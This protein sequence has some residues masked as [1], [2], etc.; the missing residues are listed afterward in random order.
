MKKKF[1]L[2]STYNK[3]GLIPL[4][5]TLMKHNY[6]LIATSG[7]ADFLKKNGLDVV[8]VE[9]ITGFPSMLGGRVKTLHP[10]VFGGILAKGKEEEVKKYDI[11]LID[12]VVVNLYPFDKEPSIEN[13]DIGGI[14]L[15]RA[16]G[17]NYRRLTCLTDPED[18]DMVIK[19]LNENSTISPDT[20]IYLARKEHC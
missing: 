16:A 5:D 15:I 7:T 9:E 14:S 13:I 18:Y 4:V 17:K 8:T 2:I 20:R 11:P 6:T 10:L 12:I 19:E 1:V 3:D